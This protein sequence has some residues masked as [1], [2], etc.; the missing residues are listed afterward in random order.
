[1]INPLAK[2][3]RLSSQTEHPAPAINHDIAQQLLDRYSADRL[4]RQRVVVAMSGG[5]DSSVA[6]AV[7]HHAGHEVIGITLQLYDNGE[8]TGRKG[9]CCAGQDIQDARNVAHLLGIPHYVLDYEKRFAD[10]VIDTFAESYIAG[11]TPIPCVA[12]NQQIK[13]RDLLE[14]A[15]ELGATSLATGHYIQRRDSKAGPRLYRALDPD[16]D[17]SYFLFATTP[18]QLA[19]LQFPLGGIA[20]DDVRTLARAFNLPVSDKPDS[21]DICFVP[22]GSYADVIERLK[23]G[24]AEPGN[25][26]HID[27]RQLGT[28]K[29]II[30]Y[31]IGQRRG[32]GIPAKEP[33]YVLKLD[34]E[35]NEVVVGPR[36][37]LRARRLILKNV[38][39]LGATPLDEAVDNEVEVFARI[40]STQDPQPAML[41]RNEDGAIIVELSDGEEGI[42][43][44]QACVF[45]AD[46]DGQAE[47]LGGG[48]IVRTMEQVSAPHAA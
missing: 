39:W 13:F 5:V 33:L 30:N 20:K 8:A 47:V 18:E 35:R 28:H 17:Q 1:M 25:I 16:R 14:T 42:A 46:G 34:A 23:P 10:A 32:L 27:G 4:G 19:M 24:A 37:L 21:Q 31:T 43:A 44:G 12:C 9:A 2:A 45:Y 3:R 26:V 36:A 38:N 11:E 15:K 48:W 7:L 41:T 29:G 22:K 6:A 40:R